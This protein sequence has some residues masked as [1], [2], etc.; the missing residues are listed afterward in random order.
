MKESV[1]LVLAS[2]RFGV[3]NKVTTLFSC[4]GCNIES[5]SVRPTPAADTARITIAVAEEQVKVRQILRQLEKLED[6]HEAVLAEEKDR[7]AIIW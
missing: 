5:L 3:L 2:N 4:R 7:G 6:V 1:F